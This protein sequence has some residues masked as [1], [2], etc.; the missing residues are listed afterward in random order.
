MKSSAVKIS[1]DLSVPTKEGVHYRLLCLTGKNKGTSY[2]LSGKRAVMG[3]GDEADVQ[4]LDAKS[5]RAHAELKKVGEKYVV[6]DLGSQNG[7]VIND[8]K[9]TQ[10]QLI[11]GDKIIIGQT[12]FKYSV[13]NNK[14]LSVVEDS[15]DEDDEEE[16]EEE[17][18]SRKPKSKEKEKKS[19][20]RLFMLIGVLGLVYFL[21]DGNDT[22]SKKKQKT[23][24]SP[25][26][27]T[28]TLNMVYNE[29]KK[30]EDKDTR[31][32][33]DTFIHRA[34]R[35]YREGNYFRA[36]EELNLCLILAPNHGYCSFLE[37]KAKQSFDA[38]IRQHFEKAKIDV[39]SLKYKAALIEYCAVVRL[40]DEVRKAGK[41][42]LRL[43]EAE[44]NIFF[45][46]EKL[47]MEKGEH[48]CF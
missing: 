30:I 8:L 28:E 32:K 7:I 12:V 19:R 4:V 42:D 16:Y 48:K 35:E 17:K 5:S 38:T 9:V 39:D 1:K 36:I 21:L 2:Y 13:H 45:V 18:T 29:Q 3:R 46:E 40:L 6:T 26:D 33:V 27:I 24:E 44:Q 43:D 47:G 41:K 31:D 23:T 10:H 20:K 11:D 34:R 14:A 22:G 15:E 25:E 37:R